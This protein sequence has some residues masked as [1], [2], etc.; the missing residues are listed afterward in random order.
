MN[1]TD[2]NNPN[3]G[4]PSPFGGTPLPDHNS[5]TSQP[6]A[7]TPPALDPV[8]PPATFTPPAADPMASGPPPMTP[9]AD[10]FSAP[11][12][13]TPPPPTDPTPIPDLSTSAIP[14]MPPMAPTPP[15]DTFSPSPQPGSTDLSSVLSPA[16]HA[17]M[18]DV[19]E[20]FTPD[21]L[22]QNPVPPPEPPASSIP[23]TSMS[24][25]TMPPSD[26][27][28]GIPG[29]AP[30]PIEATPV[31]SQN[32]NFSWSNPESAPTP[33]S[34]PMADSAASTSGLTDLYGTTTNPMNPTSDPMQTG[35]SDPTQPAPIQGE[36]APTDLSHL[37]NTGSDS[38]VYTPPLSQPETLVTTPNGGGEV[39]N[40]PT[41]DAHKGIPKWVIGVGVALL[42]VV[43]ATSAYFILG[44]GRSP[45]PASVPATETTVTPPAIN[46]TP[47]VSTAPVVTTPENGFGN[48][49]GST[50]SGAVA[51]PSPSAA[52][53]ALERLRQQQQ[54]QSPTP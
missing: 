32:S 22:P 5:L 10:P 40:V 28:F 6:L 39:P 52:I 19:G 33:L 41:G 21:S 45:Q 4:A 14:T 26:N 51:S 34:P 15:S 24:N 35:Q 37:I 43:A 29:Q 46:T 11:T 54:Q 38:T 18:S 42:L 16:Q 8:A 27:P 23:P 20:A 25:P 13:F 47:A 2:P 17:P 12:T 48:L 7:E 49:P 1:P 53:S 31:D 44:I 36:P 3:S 50:S 9:P 30:V